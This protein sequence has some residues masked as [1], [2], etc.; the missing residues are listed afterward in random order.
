MRPCC[1]RPDQE[2]LGYPSTLRKNV[3]GIGCLQ[4]KKMLPILYFSVNTVGGRRREVNHLSL[5]DIY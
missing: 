5:G 1:E 3:R 4:F 2:G